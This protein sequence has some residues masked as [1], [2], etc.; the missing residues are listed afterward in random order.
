MSECI[1]MEFGEAVDGEETKKWFNE[2]GF[3]YDADTGVLT[4]GNDQTYMTVYSQVGNVFFREWEQPFPDIVFQYV[5]NHPCQTVSLLTVD[6]KGYP[7]KK[8]ASEFSHKD[9]TTLLLNE[10]GE[11]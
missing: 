8:T 3:D 10:D 11:E 9:F 7:D 1:S 4:N 5:L 2:N 6:D